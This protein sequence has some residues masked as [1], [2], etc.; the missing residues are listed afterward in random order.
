MKLYK[1]KNALVFLF[2]LLILSAGQSLAEEKA[3]TVEIKTPTVQ[4]GMCVKTI[5]KALSH[6]D[7]VISSEV[8][9]VKKITTVKYNPEET[10]VD[11]IRKKISRAGYQADDV[12]A[13]KKAYKKLPKCCKLPEDR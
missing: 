3:K 7:G 2:A 11:D 9:K 13:Y 5:I 6:L 1:M 12:K 10:D 8:D 4:C